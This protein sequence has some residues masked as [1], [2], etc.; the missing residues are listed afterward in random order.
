MKRQFAVF[1]LASIIVGVVVLY[2][3]PAVLADLSTLLPAQPGPASTTFT[4]QPAST[5]VQ[6]SA[7]EW[8]TAGQIV[9]NRLAQ[10]LPGQNYLVVA[11]P[12]MQQIQVTVPKTADIPRILN[13]VAHTGNVVFV[14]G[15]N[16]PPAAGEP[17]AVANVLFAHSDIAEAV[18]PDPDNGELF[19]RFILNGAAAVQMHQFDAQSGNAVCLLL[20]ETVAG[21]T[22]MVYTHD[23]VIE[24]L[25][26]FGNEALG[27]DDLKIL[28]VSGPLP[29]AL[30]VV[31]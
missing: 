30:T 12:N 6:F 19:Y 1:V 18:L 28:M 29:G 22:Q 8:V 3:V 4:L 13:L 26:E 5:D 27:L 7:D 20:D 2:S 21:C 24:I 15:G 25:P 14:N 9:D 23:N 17:F 11:Q 31:N 10:L 16:K